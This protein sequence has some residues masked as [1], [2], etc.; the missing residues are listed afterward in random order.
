MRSGHAYG[1]FA[2]VAVLASFFALSAAALADPGT[3]AVGEATGAAYPSP[4]PESQGGVQDTLG[5]GE[6]PADR[7]SRDE[8][9]AGGPTATPAS[10]PGLPFTGYVA[11]I[12]LAVGLIALLAGASIRL[13]VRGSAARA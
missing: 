6:A 5:G 13:A 2:L 12:L 7:A 11:P 1:T 4:A 9:V 10:A 3:P 8:V